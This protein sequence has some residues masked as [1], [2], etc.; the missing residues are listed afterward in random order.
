MDNI[1][2]SGFM[3][4]TT[5]DII[6][7]GNDQL[8][9]ESIVINDNDVII[10]LYEWDEPITDRQKLYGII[11]LEGT[12]TGT[13]PDDETFTSLDTLC[14]MGL[15][16]LVYNNNQLCIK[17]S[18]AGTGITFTGTL[19]EVDLL[20]AE[21]PQMTVDNIGLSG[22]V[23]PMGGMMEKY[24]LLPTVK[25]RNGSIG[26]ISAQ[27]T[28]TV[29]NGSSV[30]HYR[31]SDGAYHLT[32]VDA[33][34]VLAVQR[35]TDSSAQNTIYHGFTAERTQEGYIKITNNTGATF[36]NMLGA[37][38]KVCSSN[39]ATVITVYNS[40][41]VAYNAFKYTVSGTDYYYV[42]D[43]TQTDWT[44]DLASIGYSLS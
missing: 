40:S 19:D 2:L 31:Y 12:G 3:R 41:N 15:V 44:D 5:D 8:E 34:V 7:F 22:S 27:G 26:T 30:Y 38:V 33:G 10:P 21:N 18:C 1:T 23:G 14:Q 20:V 9:P 13:I 28:Q 37:L 25:N 43:G 32:E 17:F 42:L 11:R 29:L 35:V 6:A 16:S 36:T 4:R 24:V 39:L